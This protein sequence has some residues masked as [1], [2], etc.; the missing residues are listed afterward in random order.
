MSTASG[1]EGRSRAI[2]FWTGILL[3]TAGTAMHLPMY[4]AAKGMHYKLAGMAPDRA[5]VIGM[6]LIVVGLVATTYGL[7]PRR[8]NFDAVSR[9]RVRALDD[10]RIGRAHI[11]LLL[12][13][14]VAVTIDVMKPTTLAF[15]VPGVA[16]EYG[17]RS[18]LHPSGPLPVA[19]LPLAG[20]MGTVLGSF[21][22]GSLGDRIGRRSSML[23]AG[24]LFTATA[25]CGSMP[26]FQLNLLMCFIMGIGVGGMLPIAFALLSETIPARHR[27]WL[28]VLV[29]SDIAGAYII[30]SWLSSAL[31][32][33]FG[34]RILWLIGLPT[35]LLLILLTRWVP[36]SPRFLLARGQDAAARS[37][38]KEYGA[39]II[40]VKESELDV[41]ARLRPQFGQLLRQ[42]FSSQTLVL[43]LIG[44]SL[45]LVVFGFQLW[46]PSNLRHLG[47][48]D[49]SADSLLRDAALLGLPL[50]LL[51]AY[52]YHRSSR[53]TLI[54]TSGLVAVALFGFVAL[55]NGVARNHTI[56]TALLVLPIWGSSSI[57]AVL[58]AYSSEV[59]PTR[60]RSRGTGLVAGMTKAGGVGVIALVVAAAASPSIAV[61]A[62]LGAVPLAAATAIALAV[63]VET[64]GRRLE[65]ITAE[66]LGVGA[67]AT[68]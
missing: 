49:V 7:I 11:R 12:V 5:M 25:I 6:V 23:L 10:A 19:L 60:I 45:G 67:L 13:M 38:L 24:V 61:M 62:L 63:V 43:S 21:I 16:K 58:T 66:E 17:L 41:E 1:A 27:G 8:M 55:G 22:W 39:A 4:L 26:S 32:P 3:T 46:L 54:S 52:L 56:L 14:A 50:N 28:L 18:P 68:G 37:V 59:F 20:I 2:A 53:W 9:F 44:L 35:G 47:L 31:G 48:R 34:W 30:T 33:T 29:G 65:E 64:R 57:A 40:P 51:V 42:P 15:V 36:E